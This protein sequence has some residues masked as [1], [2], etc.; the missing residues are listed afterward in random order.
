MNTLRRK[1]GWIA[2]PC[3]LLFVLLYLLPFFITIGYSL[4]HNAFDMAFVGLDNY[5]SVF[6]NRYF[7][8]AVR[9][10]LLV[11]GVL[12]IVTACLALGLAFFLQQNRSQ[13]HVGLLLLL[14]LPMLVPSVSCVA[15]WKNAFHTSA[16]ATTLTCY[17]ALVSLFAWKYTGASAV[18]LYVGLRDINPLLLDAAALDGAGSVHTYWRISLPCIRNHVT[19]M[20]MLLVMFALRIYKESYLLFGDYPSN[21]MYLLAHYMS[22][23]FIKMHYQNVAVSSV[24]LASICLVL[25]ILIHFIRN[26]EERP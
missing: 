2:L 6:S 25:F 19:I 14:L 5:A 26:R 23:H 13:R 11:T 24:S 1:I 3:V 20:V 7:Q 17:T 22:N 4:L 9:N 10:T 18:V 15:L 12:V 8:L 16:Y 21:D